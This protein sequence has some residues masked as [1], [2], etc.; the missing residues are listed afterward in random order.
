MELTLSEYL[1]ERFCSDREIPCRRVARETGKK[2]P[3]YELFAATTLVVTEVKEIEK[4]AEELES[5]RLLEETGLGGVIGRTPGDRLRAKITACSKQ[6]KARTL[7]RHPGLLVVFDERGEIPHLEPYS[8]EVAMCGLEQVYL[9]VPPLGA[10][11]PRLTGRGHGPKRKMTPAANTS[12]SAIGAL[13]FNGKD[14]E[15]VVYHNR[16][17]RVP[18][19]PPLLAPHGVMQF[20]L[21]PETPGLAAEWSRID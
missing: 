2:T 11:S 15:L 10:G 12:I 8:V 14:I 19:P 3:D 9:S 1:F 21:A 20:C 6:I 18:L 7:G 13:A 16:F 4:N 17:A 5:D